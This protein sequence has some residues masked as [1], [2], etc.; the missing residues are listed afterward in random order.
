MRE[1]ILAADYAHPARA[2]FRN[3]ATPH[4]SR[5]AEPFEPLRHHGIAVQNRNRSWVRSVRPRRAAEL[6]Y[7]VRLR[8]WASLPMV[9]TCHSLS[10]G[11]KYWVGVAVHKLTSRKFN[12]PLPV[13]HPR[14][15]GDARYSPRGP[16]GVAWRAQRPEVGINKPEL[17]IRR[18]LAEVMDLVD[19]ANDAALQTIRAQRMPSEIADPELT[20]RVVVA[21]LAC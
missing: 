3:L 21:A 18:D 2:I 16:D 13:R 9:T 7:F 4:V 19:R 14:P 11:G 1:L 8:R 6:L 10:D 5:R 17:W 20:P 12:T 15:A